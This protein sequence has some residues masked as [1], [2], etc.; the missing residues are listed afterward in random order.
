[1][2]FRS[3]FVPE[4]TAISQNDIGDDANRDAET[5]SRRKAIR[6]LNYLCLNVFGHFMHFAI[7]GRTESCDKIK[8]VFGRAETRGGRAVSVCA[9]LTSQAV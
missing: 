5:F 3:K 8:I 6:E 4:D 2:C 1:M 7:A 9:Q